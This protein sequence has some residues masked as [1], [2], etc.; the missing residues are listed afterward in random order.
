MLRKSRSEYKDDGLRSLSVSLEASSTDITSPKFD[1]RFYQMMRF[2]TV[3][4]IFYSL[5]LFHQLVFVATAKTEVTTS[6]VDYCMQSSMEPPLVNIEG[7][8][9]LAQQTST[10]VAIFGVSSSFFR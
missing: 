3:F 6:V 2:C 9:Q 1:P 10:I 7:L 5:L 4:L 8:E